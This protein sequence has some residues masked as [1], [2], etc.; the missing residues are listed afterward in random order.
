MSG[1]LRVFTFFFLGLFLLACS[2]S[3]DPVLK[4]TGLGFDPAV[5]AEEVNRLIQIKGYLEEKKS[6]P[7][8][9][10]PISISG[11]TYIPPRPF[12]IREVP[13]SGL[14][15]IV[16]SNETETQI[17]VSFTNT[18]YGQFFKP[19]KFYFRVNGASSLWTLS[20]QASSNQVSG[21]IAMAV[22]GLVNEGPIR[23][24]ICAE[25]QCIYPGQTSIRV[26][27]DTVSAILDMRNAVKCGF[28]I[29]GRGP[30]YYIQKVDLG[31]KPGRVR[32]GFHTGPIPDR[33]EIVYNGK[34]IFSTCPVLP[35]D[36]SFPKCNEDGCFT[37]V[38]N[39]GWKEFFMDYHPDNGQ[40]IQVM[41]LGW[42]T[43]PQTGWGISIS[44][45]EP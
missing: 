27:T 9:S 41:V 42:C 4:N 23:I 43:H 13:V 35:S 3:D 34:N 25:L 31:Q 8:K 21:Y 6:F 1:L 10:A 40:Y 37:I 2:K 19:A 16:I 7:G 24:T 5:H 29:T 26:I 20:F 30:S 45:P 18:D 32:I 11:F 39:N 15:T 22:P 36:F 28:T 33:L 12:F 38:P 17:P 44:C 14:D